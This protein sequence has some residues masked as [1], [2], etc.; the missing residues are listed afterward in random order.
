MTKKTIKLPGNKIQS[1]LQL[2]QSM[3]KPGQTL[4][5]NITVT[6]H[7]TEQKIQNLEVSLFISAQV[8]HREYHEPVKTLQIVNTPFILLPE[9]TREWDI[10]IPL[11]RTIPVSGNPI[12]FHVDSYITL[13]RSTNRLH[14]RPIQVQLPDQLH[15][16]LY[17]WKQAGF[18]EHP[19][20]RFFGGTA[21]E[22]ILVPE[23]QGEQLLQQCNLIV[24]LEPTGVHLLLFLTMGSES[25]V[26]RRNWFL[27]DPLLDTPKEAAEQLNHLLTETLEHPESYQVNARTPMDRLTGAT[28]S[29]A[30]G[31]IGGMILSDRIEDASSKKSREDDQL[32]TKL[33]GGGFLFRKRG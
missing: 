32:F 33:F 4:T 1:H 12:S 30:T 31:I 7:A 5:G 24:T 28:G 3:L 16:M 18:K 26:F 11:P 9:E 25:R 6:G 10:R 17:I 29:F 22:F 19:D 13:E 14:S 27:S 2:D 15:K 21:Q 8:K 23:L 20:S